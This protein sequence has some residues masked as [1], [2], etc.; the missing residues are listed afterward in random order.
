LRF[1]LGVGVGIGIGIEN[2]FHRGFVVDL[3]SDA[4]SDPDSEQSVSNV[5]PARGPEDCFGYPFTFP[6]GVKRTT[7]LLSP[8]EEVAATTA[9]MSL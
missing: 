1:Q 3:D 7:G 4:D 9:L 2:N 6:I 5:V 8:A